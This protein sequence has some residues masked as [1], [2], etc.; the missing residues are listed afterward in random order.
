MEHTQLTVLSPE[1]WLP[2]HGVMLRR[3]DDGIILSEDRSTAWHLMVYHEP[4]LAGARVMLQILFRPLQPFRTN[5][6]VNHSGGFDNDYGGFDIAV[7]GP[8]G[9]GGLAE[10][11]VLEPRDNGDVLATITYLSTAPDVYIG[12]FREA[13]RYEGDGEAQFLIREVAYAASPLQ[14]VA[15]EEQVAVLD[16]GAA[17]G[18][19]RKWRRE[20]ERIHLILVEPQAAEAA[21]LEA[22]TKFYPSASV[23]QAAL[24][25]RDGPQPFYRTRFSQCASLLKPDEAQVARYRLAPAYAVIGQEQIE[26]RRFDSLMREGRARQPDAVKADV[27]GAER[28]V[29]DGLGEALDKVL[30]IEIES[31]FYPLYQGQML[32]GDMVTWLA[33]KGFRLRW[34]RPSMEYDKD[35]VVVDAWFTRSG[36][37]TALERRKLDLIERVWKLRDHPGGASLIG[38]LGLARP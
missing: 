16:V 38:E 7:I 8:D 5:L 4:S 14:A 36:N 32:L 20:L 1:R 27:Q 23:V 26:C 29:L 11:I 12:G 35:L 31:F 2:A 15:A 25:D 13:N 6:C 34:I 37:L 18:V 21:H 17:G 33:G 3:A 19:Q 22:L 28:L 10:A 30:G 9:G 24:S